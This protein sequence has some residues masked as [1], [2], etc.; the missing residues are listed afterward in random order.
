MGVPRK[1]GFPILE[2]IFKG[3]V[4]WIYSLCLEMVQYI[5]NSLLTVFSM[6]LD[7]FFQVAPVAKDILSILIAAGWALLMGN[8]VFQAVRSMVSGLGFEGE[9]P[10]LLFTR[11]FVFAFLLLASRQICEIGL[12]ISAQIIQMLQI[13]SSV[14]V[15]I[16]EESNF[17]IGASWLLIIIVG[18]VVMWQFV[19]L[20]F[21][22]AERYVVT[23]V[24]VLM[25]PLA[26]GLGGSKSTEDIFKGWCRMFASMCLMMVM[27]IIFLKLLI[28]AMGYVPSGLGVLPWMLLIVG[29][30]RVARKIDSVVAR[31][32]LNPAITGDGLGRGLPG[33]VAFAAIRGLGMA[34][35]RSA[36]AAS[37]G[38]GGAKPRGGHATGS[39][40]PPPPSPPPSGGGGASPS[41]GGSG[42]GGQ[43]RGQSGTHAGS[44]SAPPP[45]EGGGRTPPGGRS[46]QGGQGRGQSGTYRESERAAYAASTS[47][48]QSASAETQTEPRSTRKDQPKAGGPSCPPGTKPTRHTSVPPEQRSGGAGADQRFRINAVLM[49]QRPEGAK[50]AT[51]AA[52]SQHQSAAHSRQATDGAGTFSRSYLK[53]GKEA[54]RITSERQSSQ[55]AAQ[56]RPQRPP[57]HQNGTPKI[58]APP[59][60][61][62][63]GKSDYGAGKEPDSS[64]RRDI[65][66]PT[67]T[68]GTR[69]APRPSRPPVGGTQPPAGT[70]GTR[71]PSGP[72][73]PPVG[74]TQPPAG[75]AG[76]RQASG[77]SRPPVGGT[78]PPAG[79]A[80][81][82][83]ASG[84]SRSSVGGPQPP[85]D[86]AGTRQST[87]PSRSSVGGTQPPTGTAGTRQSTGPS[88]SS[89]GGTQPP[90]GTAGTQRA[91]GPSRPPIGGTQ[92]SIGAKE[93][94]RISGAPRPPTIQMASEETTAKD[95]SAGTHRIKRP[96]APPNGSTSKKRNKKK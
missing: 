23:A 91:A 43:G 47:A 88:R 76:T 90:A 44:S 20:C 45:S 36:S 27:N 32:G 12:N 54:F 15:T 52:S 19:K 21:E 95:S 22:V 60:V 84:P 4:Q 78:Q 66:P 42:Q 86:T 68:A 46:G 89:V 64:Y 31:I 77:P 14:T 10:K 9:D 18:V 81:T 58:S 5:A 37:K 61:S 48:Q 30:A 93:S 65:Q 25:A 38:S 83:Q 26:F 63:P 53:T 56:D 71:Q 67:D 33:M 16:P 13:P 79:T 35:T 34:M 40:S 96:A 62:A 94:R 29:I 50:A 73:Q 1:G 24:L 55:Q 49:G 80:G 39:S 75:T 7:Y 17:N 59:G 51:Q 8:L 11:T 74:G 87:G 41:G 82:R 92:A 72:S 69:R 6:D 3:F 28:S 2:N 70:A 85:A 57:I